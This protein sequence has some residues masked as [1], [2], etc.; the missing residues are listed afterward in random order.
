M[1]S[2][3]QGVQNI[4][5]RQPEQTALPSCCVQSKLT[6]MDLKLYIQVLFCTNFVH[7]Q[8]QREIQNNPNS[9]HM[10]ENFEM[11]KNVYINETKIVKHLQE[12]KQNLLRRKQIIDQLIDFTKKCQ[13]VNHPIEAFNIMK[14]VTLNFTQ[15]KSEMKG[16]KPKEEFLNDIPKLS[17]DFPTT[18]DW[19]GKSLNLF[20]M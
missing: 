12:L 20:I 9:F 18:K 17:Q 6:K 2:P 1:Q 5:L 8:T 3:V 10:F 19:E 13:D 14:L 4:K 11:T 7:S 16:V 15:L